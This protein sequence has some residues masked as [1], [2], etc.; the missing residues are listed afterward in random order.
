MLGY[1]HRPRNIGV[2]QVQPGG[3]LLGGRCHF[4]TLLLAAWLCAWYQPIFAAETADANAA[5]GLEHRLIVGY[6]G[7]FGC[8]QDTPGNT[9]WEHWFT[10]NNSGADDLAV[11]LLPSLGQFSEADLCPTQ[12]RRADGSPIKVFSSQNPRVVNTH[13]RWMREHGIDGAAVQRFVGPLA[14]PPLKSR[15]DRVLQ[16]A[17]AA[18]VANARVFYVT[19]DISGAN[20]NSVVADIRRDWQY[21]GRELKITESPRYLRVNGKPVLQLWGF[22]FSDRPGAPEAVAELIDDLKAGRNNLLAATLIGGVPT[23]WRT[24]DGDS[25]SDRRWAAIYRSYDV[26]S[27]WSVGRFRDVAGIDRFVRERVLPDMAETK[28]LG[29]GYMPV[30]FPGFSWFNLQRGRGQKQIAILNQ[31]PRQCGNFLWQQIFRLLAARAD[32]LY[33]AMFDEVDEGTAL[34]PTEPHGERL[35]KGAQMAFLNQ[36]GCALPDDWYLRITGKAAY[37]LR[38]NEVPPATLDAA[39]KP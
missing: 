4:F 24:L 3:A 17:R 12:L 15:S 37:Y 23:N 25:Q 8:P 11:D 31:I 28:R 10:K 14:I 32:M 5:S 29:I 33:A 9:R 30:V 6:Q 22:G 34:F 13:F 35:P 20:A 38:R 26:L 27:P 18:A 21:L 19:Y 2:V 7:W 16:N 36:D 39:M 1:K